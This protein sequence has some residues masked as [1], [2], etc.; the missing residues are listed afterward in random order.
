M[1]PNTNELVDPEELEK[2]VKQTKAE[3][4]EPIPEELEHAA[5][6]KLKGKPSAIV[7]KT[8]GG[9]LSKWA[10]SKRKKQAQKA[11]RRRNRKG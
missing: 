11:A 2:L 7:S 8:S 5:K 9:K 3:G 10:A 6:V 1:N 4:F